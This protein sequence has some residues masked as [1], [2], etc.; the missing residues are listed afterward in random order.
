MCLYI[1]MHHCQWVCE[2]PKSERVCTLQAD[3]LC[4][5]VCVI[6][7][8]HKEELS[9]GYMNTLGYVLPT[10]SMHDVH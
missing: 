6:E 4:K 8:V 1:Y 9:Y 3:C 7:S 2:E 5:R 10:L